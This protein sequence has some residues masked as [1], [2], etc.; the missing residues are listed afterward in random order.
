MGEDIFHFSVCFQGAERKN[1][2]GRVS[3]G[4]TQRTHE[5]R[6][7]LNAVKCLQMSS[8]AKDALRLKSNISF[9]V[10][11]ESASGFLSFP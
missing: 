4:A 1:L 2:S 6:G 3:D 5:P 11:T 10:I 7:V 8:Y 9:N